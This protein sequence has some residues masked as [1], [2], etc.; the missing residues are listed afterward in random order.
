MPEM[1]GEEFV[2]RLREFNKEILVILQ[3]GYSDQKPPIEMLQSLDIQGY[4]DKTKGLDE[5]IL[6]VLSAIKTSQ[7]IKTVEQKDQIIDALTYKNNIV[8]QLVTGVINE[9]KDQ[10]VIISGYNGA[11]RD[12]H[13]VDEIRE[14]TDKIKQSL[15]KENDTIMAL[16]I[17]RNKDI[18]IL[19]LIKNIKILTKIELYKNFSDLNFI[20]N[21]DF[22][23]NID[24][25]TSILTYMLV[26]IIMY[27]SRNNIKTIN[28]SYKLED[29]LN[30]FSFEDELEFEES[31]I[32][33]INLLSSD[34]DRI[35]IDILNNKIKVIF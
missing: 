15:E 13:N 2:K 17:E 12:N 7:L 34:D 14:Y 6:L 26:E 24:C 30:A 19:D 8:G 28:M 18:S 29:N 22:L 31:F 25:N 20:V 11:I 9:M 1:T 5:L 27:L 33:K 4:F 35:K 32:N 10:I 21:S 16:N 3:T 23:G